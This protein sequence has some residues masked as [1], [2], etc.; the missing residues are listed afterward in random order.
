LKI[1][2][3]VPGIAL[4]AGVLG[5]T[6]TGVSLPA[7]TDQPTGQHEPGRIVWR[8]LISDQP[9]AS[10]RFYSE[11]FGW[12]FE[13]VGALFG[14]GGEDAYSLIRHNGQLIGGMV[15]EARLENS[16]D[17][18]SQW[19][20]L[21]SVD[22]IESASEKFVE[23]GGSILTPPTD[24]A[25]RGQM[26]VVVDPQGALIAL[27]ETRDG[28]PAWQEPDLGDFLW[29]ELWTS[30][31]AASTGFY[32]DL[33]G[34]ES[35]QVPV[36]GGRAYQVLT[37][38][39]QPTAGVLQHPFGGERP[40]WVTYIRVEDPAAITARVEEL[41]GT[42]Y[43]EAQDRPLGGQVALIADPSGAGIAVQSWSFDESAR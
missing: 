5:C 4:L 25:D 1:R 40:V 34:L 28:D 36:S 6:A 35:E 21:M 16:A 39:E 20:V 27:V 11:L 38:D 22:D 17:D 26:S 3:I 10:R 12:E 18:I 8:D 30:D 9:A 2:W 15:N 14:L 42:V 24:V 41:G 13:G 37:R 32:A 43:V 7:L 33:T 19:V 29:D 23:R 31:V